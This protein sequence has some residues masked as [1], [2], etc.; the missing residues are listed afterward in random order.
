VLIS[1]TDTGEGILKPIASGISKVRPGR[2]AHRGRAHCR[3]RL[4]YFAAGNS[5]ISKPIWPASNLLTSSR[6]LTIPISVSPASIAT[7]MNSTMRSRS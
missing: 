6:S 3:V 4:D 7:G 2:G 5:V 1:V